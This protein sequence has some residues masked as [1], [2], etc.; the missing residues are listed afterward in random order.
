MNSLQGPAGWLT[1][2]I[3]AEAVRLVLELCTP[4]CNPI[5]PS[6]TFAASLHTWRVYRVLLEVFS[7]LFLYAV[8]LLLAQTYCI[9]R[10]STQTE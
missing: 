6:S 4:K 2:G 8:A 10:Y 9:K 7:Y 3:D 5:M 1:D